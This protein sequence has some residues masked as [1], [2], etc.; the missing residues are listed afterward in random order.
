MAAQEASK[1]YQKYSQLEHILAR[2]DSYVGSLEKET[3]KQWI[4]N[5]ENKFEQKY[6]THV[7]GLYKIYDEIL[8]NAID[9]TSVDKSVD[10]IKVTV[11]NDIITVMNTGK[12][13]PIEMHETEKVYIPEMIF[14]ELLTSSNYDDS[15]KRTVGGRN[16]YG[17]KLANVFSEMFELEVVDVDSQKKFNITWTNN[18]KDK[19][20]PTITKKKCTNGYVKI[21]FKP[22]LKRF[23]MSKLDTDTCSLFEKRVYDACA[24]TP[25]HVSVYYNNKKLTYKNF[26]KY[27]DLYI[28]NK[29]ETIRLYE[30]S[31]RWDVCVCHSDDGYKQVSFVNGISTSVG[32]THVEHVTRQLVNKITDKILQKNANSQ[33]KA[34]FIKEHM[35]VFVKAVLE[36]PSFSSQ[37]KTECTLKVQSFGSKFECSEDFTKKLMKLGIMDDALALAKH[38]EMREL[39]KTDGKKKNTIKI[40]KLDDANWAGGSKSEQTILMLT[41]GDSA[42]TFAI[43]GLSVV[44]RD[45]YGVFPLRGK[46]LNVRDATAKQLMDNVEINAIKQ[47]MGLQQGKEYTSLSDLRYGGIQI[48][49]DADV[50][51]SHIKGLIINW[52]HNFWPSLLKF[53]N[54]VTAMIT[55]VIKATKSN[56]HLSFYSL[57]AYNQWKNSQTTQGFNIKYYKGLGTSTAAEAK[58]YFK[59]MS[60]NTVGYK[61]NDKTD[62][63]IN[64]A[65][66]KD[67]ADNRKKWILDGIIANQL[68]EYGEENQKITYE[69]FINKDM[70]WFSISDNERSIPSA[71][72][73]F[74]PSQRKVIFGARKRKNTEIKVSQLASYVSTESAY[75]HGEVSLQGTIVGL[76]QTFV[77]SNNMEL[78]EP[79]GQFGSRLMGGKDAASSRYIFTRLAH[80]AHNL[81]KNE[82]DALLQYLDDDGMKIEPRYYVP[83]LPIVLINGAEG[84][85]TGYSTSVPSYNPADI[86]KNIHNKLKGLPLKSMTPWYKGFKGKI[87]EQEDCPG[88]YITYGVYTQIS[89][90]KIEITELPI[91][92]WTQNYKELLEKLPEDKV[93]SITNH[94][95]DDKVHFIVKIEKYALKKMID[96]NTIYKEFK[97]TS[98][99]STKNMH[100]FDQNGKIKKYESPLHIIEDFC[101]VRMKY[102]ELR[103]A[104]MIKT[105]KSTL[106]VLRNKVKFIKMIVSNELVVSKK[107]KNILESEL[108]TLEFTKVDGKYDYL[109]N[110]PIYNLTL[111]K[112]EDLEKTYKKSKNELEVIQQTEVISMWEKEL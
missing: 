27:V 26:E 101:E 77:G 74:K 29:K 55:P 36:N 94:S 31:R 19:T 64:L 53:D 91:G 102:Y 66:K 76:A 34:N 81:I 89:P 107:A 16:G 96:S 79:K 97:L 40:P 2:P 38:K 69:D 86:S 100:L 35:F 22:D 44:G 8:V 33:V 61:Y 10:S 92:T 24:C 70:I 4:L 37:T 90:N 12:G 48:I 43:S 15:V 63:Y 3:E 58:E 106:R 17:A 39:S 110:M 87:Q 68:I 72:D 41:E 59:H 88:S 13:I 14:G 30:S 47:I 42:K 93:Q 112:I 65:F 49:T 9:Q 78:L 109:L 6:I 99:I 25:E 46:M 23:N 1:K 103:K 51:G 95:T 60:Q 21:T 20:K 50:D 80:N 5:V 83:I 75:H 45:K 28:G 104:H 54:F 82:D 57:T 52:L 85:G 32:G 108:N 62:A 67:Q 105:M 71:I 11:E 18:M 56:E 84:I 7:P 73:G 98:N 111:E